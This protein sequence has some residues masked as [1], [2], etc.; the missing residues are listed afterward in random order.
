MTA[1]G[2]CRI[3]EL[4]NDVEK[5]RALAEQKLSGLD[6]HRNGASDTPDVEAAI[7]ALLDALVAGDRGADAE[8]PTAGWG[9][10]DNL[11]HQGSTDAPLAVQGRVAS[12]GQLLASFRARVTQR[13]AELDTA[14]NVAAELRVK[15]QRYA[16]TGSTDVPTER[17]NYDAELVEL[18]TKCEQAE[19]DVK[20]LTGERTRLIDKLTSMKNASALKLQAE[21]ET[22]ARLRPELAHLQQTINAHR[23][24][25]HAAENEERL[26]KLRQQIAERDRSLAHREEQAA[27]DRDAARQAQDKVDALMDEAD[28][29]KLEAQKL[30]LEKEREQQAV[31]NLT[32][33]LADRAADAAELALKTQLVDMLRHDLHNVH[34]LGKALRRLHD[35]T[36]SG[37]PV[38]KQVAA[39][40]LAGFLELPRGDRK[41][42]D[43]LNVLASYLCLEDQDRV[44]IGLPR[45]PAAGAGGTRSGPP[46]AAVGESFTD[47]W[48]SFLLK[49][50]SKGAT[51]QAPPPTPPDSRRTSVARLQPSDLRKA[52]TIPVGGVAAPTALSLE[53]QQ[54][55]PAAAAPS[56][57]PLPITADAPPPLASDKIAEKQGQPADRFQTA[58]DAQVKESN[59]EDIFK[60]DAVLFVYNRLL[61]LDTPDSAAMLPVSPDIEP[62]VPQKVLLDLAS[63][64]TS[65]ALEKCATYV[66]VFRSHLTFSQATA[67]TAEYHASICEKSYDEQKAQVAALTVALTNL[68]GYSRAVCE[69]FDKFLVAGGQE[70]ALL[71]HDR[72]I[73]E[74]RAKVCSE[75]DKLWIDEAC[76]EYAA[77]NTKVPSA[78]GPNNCLGYCTYEKDSHGKIKMIL[79]PSD[80]PVDQPM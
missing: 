48:I 15:L 77:L 20:R 41:R 6:E 11:N 75:V 14:H 10:M 43:V 7:L 52:S 26:A 2:V 76:P 65:K 71:I 61:L 66:D 78:L 29:L 79:W 44:T 32:R 24:L 16:A 25:A 36:A 8:S 51:D 1:A 47:M 72:T 50:S 34:Q 35:T 57:Q 70:L 55:P 42:Y 19:A 62:P 74:N 73:A 53:G 30:A 39:S 27:R 37:D 58:A 13:E 49:E 64:N 31:E 17:Q 38:D 3:A 45:G 60:E 5:Y 59:V 46:N 4:E 68:G 69:A 80:Y 28:E 40:L 23:Q 63:R 56:P 9:S 54:K 21:M 67:R 18:R 12:L 33:L 22:S